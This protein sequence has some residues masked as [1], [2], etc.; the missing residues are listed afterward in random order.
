MRPASGP[1][2]NSV[3]ISACACEL[4]DCKGRRRPRLAVK[5]HHMQKGG[6][7]IA[8]V[9]VDVEERRAKPSARQLLA[10]GGQCRPVPREP[11]REGFVIIERMR[12][13]FRQAARPQQTAR[14]APDENIARASDDRQTAP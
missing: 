11:E 6:L 4:I 1:V 13:E 14:D 8:G 3:V 12:H 2:V 7:Q 10:Q 9:A 5:P